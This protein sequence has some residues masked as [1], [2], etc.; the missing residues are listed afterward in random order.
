MMQTTG[1]F[2]MLLWWRHSMG[3]PWRDSLGRR[4]QLRACGKEWKNPNRNTH[5]FGLRT[6]SVRIR[7][8]GNTIAWIHYSIFSA[9]QR[10][11]KRNQIGNNGNVALRLCFHY[12]RFF[13]HAVP[14][15]ETHA[16]C[17][18]ICV[19][20]IADLNRV[21]A[22]GLLHAHTQSS[23]ILTR[24]SLQLGPKHSQLCNL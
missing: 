11:E 13:P 8:G 14:F 3:F 4:G 10:I 15:A 23:L 12:S 19:S 5:A 18:R 1:L 7:E 24:T 17:M 16:D 22:G 6:T 2:L 21:S 20:I 9:P